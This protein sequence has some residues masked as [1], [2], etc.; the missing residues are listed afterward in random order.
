M[1]EKGVPAAR[2]LSG[3]EELS[4]VYQEMADK[5]Y[6]YEVCCNRSKQQLVLSVK[7]FVV[8]INK[9]YQNPHA[10]HI[11]LRFR[12]QKTH[13]LGPRIKNN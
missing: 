13:Q 2:C 9:C 6:T 7:Y 5:H 1:E 10:C 4:K 11:P 8:H 3:P 12:I